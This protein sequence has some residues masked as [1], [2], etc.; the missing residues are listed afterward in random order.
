[1]ILATFPSALGHSFN[2]PKDWPCAELYG[3]TVLAAATGILE[4]RARPLLAA[5]VWLG[6]A[7]SAKF[8]AVF[9]LVTIVAWTP[10]AYLA[11]Y[12]PRT[13]SERVVGAYLIAPWVAFAVFFKAWPWLSHGKYINEWWHALSDYV[14]FMVDYGVVKERTEWT[15]YPWRCLFYTT[16]PI[17]LACAAVFA[18]IG[19]RKTRRD[20]AVWALLL[21]WTGLPLVRCSA[22]H[23]N[24]YDM[25]RHF[26]EYIPG[27][28]AMAG[29]GAWRI[30]EL[31]RALLD[32]FRA[33][34][35]V[36]IAGSVVGAG[37]L[38]AGLVL[39]IAAYHPYETTYFNV[40]IGGLGGAQRKALLHDDPWRAY[41]TEGD[42]WYSAL[43][44]AL[45]RMTKMA[46]PD[47]KIGVDPPPY[48]P[49]LF[50]DIENRAKLDTT[51]PAANAALLYVGPSAGK[52]WRRIH[53]LEAERPVRYRE[54]RGGGLIY[55]VLGKADGQKHDLVS[56][57][58]PY[59]DDVP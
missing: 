22:P 30:V 47:E 54:V 3:I 13:V 1:V 52:S 59:D 55:E 15:S 48:T 34:P 18:V 32:R 20:V 31:G 11:L 4:Q 40:F 7:L 16:P 8:N 26:I 46:G 35:G 24:F 42:Y 10:I 19:W 28:A 37:I 56:P 49:Q 44:G 41:G 39:P 43:R 17:V 33:G 50:A 57:H 9:V 5:G 14:T 2:N 58:T 53:E 51:D 38:A 6:L 21:L 23:A 29:A 36:R 25:N 12:R 45:A 27:L